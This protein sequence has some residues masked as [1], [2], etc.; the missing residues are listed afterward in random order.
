MKRA[1]LFLAMLFAAADARAQIATVSGNLKDLGVN[2]ATQ[3]NTYV[4]F[5]LQNFT[6]IPRVVGTNTIVSQVSAPFKPDGSGNISGSIQE[7]NSITPANTFYQVCVYF[8]GNRFQ[9][10][11]FIISANFNLNTAIPL[12]QATFPLPPSMIGLTA[13]IPATCTVGMV[14]FA[15][16]ATAGD[17]LFFC[18]APN[19]WTQQLS[20][21]GSSPGG[22]SGNVQYNQA[23]VMGG[24]LG[25]AIIPST[26]AIALTPGADTTLP[27]QIN[28]HSAT[29]SSPL[30][31]I[32]HQS[33]GSADTP[34][35]FRGR[36]FGSFTPAAAK[37]MVH[38]IEETDALSHFGLVITNHAADVTKTVANY[39]LWTSGVNDSGFG[40]TCSGG[41]VGGVNNYGCFNWNAAG[42]IVAIEGAPNSSANFTPFSVQA[43]SGQN[44]DIFDILNSSGAVLCRAD[45]N[46]VFDGPMHISVTTGSS[47]AADGY[48]RTIFMNQEATAGAA[49]TYTLPTAANG[50]MKCVMNSNNG[51]APDTGV[52]TLQTSAAGQFII[53][54]DGTLTASGGF[55]SSGGAAADNACVVGVDG[56]HWQLMVQ[57][58]TWA[59]H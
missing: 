46:G 45:Q 34:M 26:G 35:V 4:L 32:N 17:N 18:T 51:S 19:T 52:L 59:K 21:G 48:S 23:G 53:F 7:N 54:T 47:P 43:T 15:T 24:I 5:K 27:L 9:C 36:G 42:G 16:D 29:Q 22:I 50:L 44:V 33:S 13:A 30:I 37:G 41:G 56:T 38:I 28:S 1:I 6:G 8:Q 2:N 14:Y 25:S 10:N 31:D 57:Q 55:V 58:G 20:G 40:F 3:Q 39:A 12:T 11:N 49:V